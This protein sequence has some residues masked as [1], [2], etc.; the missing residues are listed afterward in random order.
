MCNVKLND[1]IT[2]WFRNSMFTITEEN[3]TQPLNHNTNSLGIE[4]FNPLELPNSNLAAG[5]E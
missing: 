1:V 4:I 2:V 3:G 5:T